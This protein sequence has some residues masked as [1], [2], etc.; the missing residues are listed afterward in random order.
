MKGQQLG[1]KEAYGLLRGPVAPHYGRLDWVE[2]V[3]RFEKY[4]VADAGDLKQ[5]SWNANYKPV[6][7][8]V[9]ELMASRPV[10]RDS[11]V[12]LAGLRDRYGGEPG[13]RGRKMR[14]Q[15]AAQ[16]LRFSVVALGA[17]DR[18]LPPDDLVPFWVM[19]QRA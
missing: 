5:A 2:L 17:A 8:Q 9:L 16:L 13:S 4:K 3:N 15:Y 11:R 18:S 6:M 10:Q 1:L 19:L 7:A 12:L 14:S